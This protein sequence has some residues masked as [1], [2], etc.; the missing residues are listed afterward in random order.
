MEWT[1][2]SGRYEIFLRLLAGDLVWVDTIETLD[3]A[4]KRLGEL[5]LTVTSDYALFDN[6]LSGFVRLPDHPSSS[7][8]NDYDS[9]DRSTLAFCYNS[10]PCSTCP[11]VTFSAV[12]SDVSLPKSPFARASQS[13]TL[14]VVRNELRYSLNILGYLIQSSGSNFGSFAPMIPNA[15]SSVRTT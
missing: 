6:E 11:L 1:P 14:S 13:C 7:G 12:S 10:G 4:V 5:A 3:R 8:L 2:G 9:T 15:S